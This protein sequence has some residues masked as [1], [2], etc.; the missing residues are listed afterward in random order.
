MRKIGAFIVRRQFSDIL[1]AHN[2]MYMHDLVDRISR[3][4]RVN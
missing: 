4:N 1:Y 2:Y 3:L